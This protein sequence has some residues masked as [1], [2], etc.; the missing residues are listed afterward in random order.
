[1][2][3]PREYLQFSHDAFPRRSENGWGGG[4]RTPAC[5]DQNLVP[6]QLGDTPM[7]IFRRLA[8][9]RLA[10]DFVTQCHH[11]GGTSFAIDRASLSERHSKKNVLPEPDILAAPYP[12]NQR[13]GSNLLEPAAY[14]WLEVVNPP[15]LGPPRPKSRL[16]SSPHGCVS[17]L[18]I[19]RFPGCSRAREDSQA[20]TTDLASQ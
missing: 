12:L 15:L 18:W 17:I 2:C 20:G 3:I 7:I 16:L 14:Y 8:R 19:G 5:K 11:F 10:L 6:Y 13:R 1:M 9:L 4:T